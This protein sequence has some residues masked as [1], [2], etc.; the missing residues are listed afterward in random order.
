M[1]I[2]CRL[3][4]GDSETATQL[5]FR[6]HRVW[7]SGRGFRGLGL[8]DFYSQQ[9]RIKSFRTWNLKWKLAVEP[10]FAVSRRRFDEVR[11]SALRKQEVV[12]P[13][14]HHRSGA[15]RMSLDS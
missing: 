15:W 3:E 9:R 7:N 11:T 13:Q 4:A 5:T 1:I 10:I 12:A 2:C 8:R 6:R 14:G